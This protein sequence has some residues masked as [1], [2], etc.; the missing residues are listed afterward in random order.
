M[1]RKRPNVVQQTPILE[2]KKMNWDP[3]DTWDPDTVNPIFSS[4]QFV[5]SRGPSLSIH[6]PVDPTTPRIVPA[7]VFPAGEPEGAVASI[8]VGSQMIRKPTG[9][10]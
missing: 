3:K 1:G 4:F 8:T 2:A 10:L 5:D 7:V 9:H 6:I